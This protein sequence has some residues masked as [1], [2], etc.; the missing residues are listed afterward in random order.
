MQ[1]AE[2]YIRKEL[3]VFAGITHIGKHL[4]EGLLVI[5]SYKLPGIVARFL[6]S[7]KIINTRGRIILVFLMM[8]NSSERKTPDID[9]ALG[10][11]TNSKSNNRN[12]KRRQTENVGNLK[13]V[14]GCSSEPA[15]SETRKLSQSVKLLRE[16]NGVNKRC[17]K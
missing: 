4:R 14:V 11:I 12:H 10:R 1:I 6:F 17:Y 8:N 16:R 13:S 2:E 5:L 7:I 3:V 15:T 9:P